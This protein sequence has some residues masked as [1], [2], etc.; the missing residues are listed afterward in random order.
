MKR[1][2]TG[3][4]W[5]MPE[6]STYSSIHGR[7]AHKTNRYTYRV[8]ALHQLA[9]QRDTVERFERGKKREG[10]RERRRG[11]LWAVVAFPHYG[12]ATSPKTGVTNHM[13]VDGVSKTD[14]RGSFES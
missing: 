12:L 13:T 9:A 7:Q 8:E 5:P 1:F 11:A 10:Q 2:L 3:A 14:T 6:T 4:M